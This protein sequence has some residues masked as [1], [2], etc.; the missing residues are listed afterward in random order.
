MTPDRPIFRAAARNDVR[1]RDCNP[2]VSEVSTDCLY[3]VLRVEARAQSGWR[4]M[5][6]M[7]VLSD[8]QRILIVDD[9]PACWTVLDTMF[10]QHGFQVAHIDSV[11]GVSEFVARFRPTVILLDLALPYRSGASWLTQLRSQP[12]TAS[13]PVVILSALPDVLPRERRELAQAVVR[14][15]FQ[16]QTLVETVQAVCA[17][18]P[19]AQTEITTDP[20]SI[21]RRGSP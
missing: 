2:G 13:I 12:A 18:T 10:E 11:L 4:W 7:T 20:V 8:G 1:Q 19:L 6:R 3:A 5:S 21:R 15:P 16:A 9:D 17:R 14:K